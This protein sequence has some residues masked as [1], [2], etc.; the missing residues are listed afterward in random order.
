MPVYQTI[1][2]RNVEDLTYKDFLATIEQQARQGVD[3]FTIH[4]G[5]LKEHLPL[6]AQRTAGIVS[7]GGSLLTK[8][9][10]YHNRQNPMYD[11]FD[12]I[13]GLLHDYDVCYSLGDGLRPGCLADA[14]DEAQIAECGRWASWCSGRE[15][16]AY[17]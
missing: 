13:S 9:M 7:K 17:R 8:W 14:T 12:D 5:V 11:M 2:G 15:N 1:Q 4:A 16:R 3:Y 10:L 6:A